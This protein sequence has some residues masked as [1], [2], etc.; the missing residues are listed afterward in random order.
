M[1]LL[2]AQA[3][4]AK[5][6]LASTRSRSS[7]FQPAFLSAA[8]EAGIGPD[9]HDRRIDAGMRPGDDAGERLEP[10][11]LGF[12]GA[13]QDDRGRAVIDARGIGGGDR[14]VLLRRPA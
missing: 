6:S 2:T 1:S 4:A 12:L 8:R 3:W 7:T 9:A 14:A 5:A 10:A 11:L 13:H